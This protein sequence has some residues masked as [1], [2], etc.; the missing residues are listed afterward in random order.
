M[1][2]KRRTPPNQLGLGLNLL[3]KKTRKREFLDEMDR[4]VPWGALVQIVEPHSPRA[5]T[6]DPA[7]RQTKK[8]N[9][10]YFGMKAHI[11]V[12]TTSGLVHTVVGTAANVRDINVAG[13]LLHG[14]EHAAFGDSGYQGVHKR[15]EAAG[16]TWHVAM[17][18]GKRKL[19]NPF[20][21]P[22]FVAERVEIMRDRECKSYSLRKRGSTG[23]GHE[24]HR[25]VRS[26]MNSIAPALLAISAA[27]SIGCAQ[28]SIDS[29]PQSGAGERFSLGDAAAVLPAFLGHYAVTDSRMNQRLVTSVDL[30]VDRGLPTLRL[31][32]PNG[33]PVMQIKGKFGAGNV[34]DMVSKDMYLVCSE[35]DVQTGRRIYFSIS[36]VPATHVYMADSMFPVHDPMPVTSGFLLQYQPG[37][38][39]SRTYPLALRLDEPAKGTEPS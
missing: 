10:W 23:P 14:E 19:L 4:V 28:K 32:G 22:E 11:G 18:A 37:D 36:K 1:F 33:K 39:N 5:K 3:T 2:A 16:P 29:V 27:L 34:S 35:P 24:R 6:R 25:C 21:E 20:I 8:G 12:D 9:Q 17:R 31:N 7:M 38:H 30:R 26:F 15:V 13:M